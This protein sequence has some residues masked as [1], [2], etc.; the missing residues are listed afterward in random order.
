MKSDRPVLP[1]EDILLPF[2]IQP[3]YPIEHFVNGKRYYYPPNVPS[4]MTK[5]SYEAL[6]FTDDGKQLGN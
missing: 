2:V 5:E 1:L 4:F 6:L 3:P